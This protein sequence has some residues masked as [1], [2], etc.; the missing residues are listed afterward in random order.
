MS[1]SDESSL[2]PLFDLARIESS[3]ESNALILTPNHR[4]KRAI[5]QAWNQQQQTL[6]TSWL[7]PKVYVLEEWLLKQ[8]LQLQ[9]IG[10]AGSHKQLITAQQL[11]VIWEK[12]LSKHG[13]LHVDQLSQQAISAVKTLTHWQIDLHHNSELHPQFVIWANDVKQALLSIN[14]ITL[15]KV[16]EIILSAY[17]NK[18]LAIEES[19]ALLDFDDVS[20]L[21]NSIIESG[22]YKKLDLQPNHIKAQLSRFS[23][24]DSQQEKQAAAQWAYQI[25]EQDPHARIGIIAPELG[26]CRETLV[27]AFIE[28]FEAHSLSPDNKTYTLPFNISTGTPLGSTPLISAT[29]NLLLLLVD[30]WDTDFISECLMS[31]FWGHYSEELSNRCRLIE[32]LMSFGT[33]TINASQL[34]YWAEKLGSSESEDDTLFSYF[35]ALHQLH[36]KAS[37]K[38]SPSQWVELILN[39]LDILKWPGERTPDSLEYQ[40]TQQWYLLLEQFCSLDTVLEKISWQVAIQRLHLM[41]MEFPFQAKVPDS[42]IQILGILEGAGL[43]FT[44]CWI[45]GMHQQAWPPAPNPNPL[46]PFSLQR[47]HK[48]PNASSQRELE[49]AKSLTNNYRHCADNI[50][51]SAAKK[52]VGDETALQASALISDIPLGDFHSTNNPYRLDSWKN[53]LLSHIPLKFIDCRKAPAIQPDSSGTTTVLPGGADLLKI[54][55]QNPFD[56]LIKYRLGGRETQAPTQGFNAAEKGQIL[57]QALASLW[58]NLGTQKALISLPKDNLDKLIHSSLD[59]SINQI[60]RQKPEHLTPE[61]C[62]I[63][64]ERQY[65]LI[66]QWLALEQERAIFTVSTTEKTVLWQQGPFALKMRVDR[67]DDLHNGGQLFIDYKTGSASINDWQ[68]ERLNEP[69]LPLYAISHQPAPEALA[70]AQINAKKIFFTGLASSQHN[71]GLTHNIKACDK[72]TLD[73]PK[74][75]AALLQDWE[76]KLSQLLQEFISGECSNH[77]RDISTLAQRQSWSPWTLRINR[78]YEAEAIKERIT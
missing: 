42:P 11:Q 44:H 76:K 43:H 4:L 37:S 67:I 1:T 28:E 22:C 65:K 31:P 50:V 77:Y 45:L 41:S 20:P 62:H 35:Y 13:V 14:A 63:E 33:L 15:E 38:Q 71:G 25:L 40:Q 56:A 39:V 59:D 53:H 48:M 72:H 12:V 6:S 2:P 60:R 51:F 78:F 30:Q 7:P 26:Q 18:D 49:Y 61:L 16:Y 69:Q 74:E 27:R 29:H 54:Q 5:I 9:N 57:H 19:I 3:L 21:V 66:Y 58:E 36:Q 10:Y 70:F 32:K 46:I 73:L 55:A 17:N 24:E 64:Q 34:R 75:W 52:E 68:G 8:W 23:F 47:Q